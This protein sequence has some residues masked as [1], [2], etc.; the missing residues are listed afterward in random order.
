MISFLTKVDAF[1]SS[2]LIQLTENQLIAILHTLY[3]TAKLTNG[4]QSIGKIRVLV[5]DKFISLPFLKQKSHASC[6][7]DSFPF[8]LNC[9]ITLGLFHPL[10]RWTFFLKLKHLES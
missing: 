5:V 3:C 2:F 8:V 7:A 1:N 10:Q 9:L 6:G 4:F